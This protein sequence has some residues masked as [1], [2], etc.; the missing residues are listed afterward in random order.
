MFHIYPQFS[1]FHPK[2][3]PY[4][5]WPTR[6][7]SSDKNRCVDIVVASAYNIH[8]VYFSRWDAALDS[9]LFLSRV[10]QLWL[11]SFVSLFEISFE[12]TTWAVLMTSVKLNFSIDFWP[13]VFLFCSETFW[14]FFNETFFILV[15]IWD[16]IFYLDHFKHLISASKK[17]VFF[18]FLNCSFQYKIK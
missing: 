12:W 14:Y 17:L 15:K 10:V 3:T 1:Y 5:L 18:N 2:K 16:S 6:R 4:M 11:A 8:V 7:G 13:I 9:S